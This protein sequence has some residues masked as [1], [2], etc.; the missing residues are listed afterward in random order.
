M[1][2]PAHHPGFVRHNPP[3]ANLGKYVDVPPTSER[4]DY[5]INGKPSAQQ[6]AARPSGNQQQQGT[7]APAQ[8]GTATTAPSSG[9]Q[10]Q[11]TVPPAAPV[12]DGRTR[13]P[14]LPPPGA[15]GAPTAA[16]VVQGNMAA[17]GALNARVD[18]LETTTCGICICISLR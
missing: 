1:P 6:T 16:Q 14:P 11:T 10:M 17:V 18:G 5:L 15:S 8:Q 12:L 9:Q 7:T 2:K 13:L 4:R 3:P